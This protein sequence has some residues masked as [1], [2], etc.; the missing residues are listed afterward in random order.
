[1]GVLNVTPDSFSD[2]GHYLR[3]DDALRQ[4]RRMAQE[5]ASILDV[6]GESTRPGADPV[7]EQ[8]EL[9][10][11]IPVIERLRGE[12]GC[13]ISIDTMKPAVMDAACA[14]GALM[15][16]DVNA[17]RRPGALEVA[18]R[19]GAIVC[20]MHMRGEPRTM[21]QAPEYRDVV[22]DVA[23]FLDER[24]R[25]SLAA[26][27][28]AER[29]VLDPGIGFGKTLDQNLELLANL[30]RIGSGA[31]AVMIGVSRK[32]MFGQA[33]GAPVDARLHA[34]IATA[35]LA[36]WQG[37]TIVRAHDVGATVD[38]L[39]LAWRIRQARR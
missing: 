7:S 4:A 38:A 9:D 35:A 36:V 2:G 23:S 39:R 25:A 20:L 26:G 22:S 16:N 33:L 31:A 29:I 30:D 18:S 14:A 11:V 32:S 37:V 13:L 15:I 21:Q 28:A 19:H 3:L 5:G 17:L 27:I 6:G 10:R 24:R 1:M 8:Q 12:T 34:S